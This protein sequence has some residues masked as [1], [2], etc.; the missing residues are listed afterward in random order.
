MSRQRVGESGNSL[1]KTDSHTDSALL[2]RTR[3][4]TPTHG[5]SWNSRAE[6]G[7]NMSSDYPTSNALMTYTEVLCIL[8]RHY[9][10]L[11]V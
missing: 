6:R 5:T 8:S 10:I 11:T 7:N 1:I 9:G 2:L 4:F 3:G